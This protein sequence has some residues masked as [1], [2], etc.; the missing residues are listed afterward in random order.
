MFNWYQDYRSVNNNMF[1]RN[2][3]L[4]EVNSILQTLQSIVNKLSVSSPEVHVSHDFHQEEFWWDDDYVSLSMSVSQDV[5]NICSSNNSEYSSI[6][7]DSI[8]QPV[9]LFS[10]DNTSDEENELSIADRVKLRKVALIQSENASIPESQE[11]QLAMIHDPF[12]V[13]MTS[14][15]KRSSPDQ[16][17]SL[18]KSRKRKMKKAAKMVHPELLSVWNN[19][20]DLF[21]FKSLAPVTTNS[22]VP[23]VD[24]N[25]V[26]SRHIANVPAPTPQPMHGCSSDPDFDQDRC[27]RKCQPSGHIHGK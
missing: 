5:N 19:V 20:G 24:W 23:V 2:E 27:T 13:K 18:Q 26:N 9:E 11:P 12:I 1:S 7:S 14:F 22:S 25:K 16:V 21:G 6:I 17:F 10:D 3:F 15:I 8:L 4:I